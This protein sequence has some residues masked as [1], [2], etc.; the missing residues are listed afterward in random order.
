VTS[1][2][3]L[4]VRQ[5]RKRAQRL[6][7]FFR[8]SI[9]LLFSLMKRFCFA[10]APESL[11]FIA[12]VK[13]V[14]AAQRRDR[15]ARHV[16]AGCAGKDDSSPVRGGTV[17][18][19]KSPGLRPAVENSKIVIPS[20]PQPRGLR[21]ED[22]RGMCF[23]IARRQPFWLLRN[24]LR[25]NLLLAAILFLSAW[26]SAQETTILQLTRTSRPWEFLCA[27]GTRAGIFGDESGRIEAW[28][29]PL[30]ILRNF[31][32][33]FEIDG[34]LIPAETL[35]RTVTA[36]PESVSVLYTG[37]T[38]AVRE[39]FFVPV[40]EPGALILLDVDTSQPLDIRAA[41]ERDF[42]LEWPAALGGTF[43]SWDPKL[44]AFYFGE[45]Q[46]KFAA[47][48][49]SPTADDIR[50]EYQTNYSSS[51]ESSFDLGVI[52]GKERKLVVIAA[53]TQGRPDA[54]SIFQRLS[55]S[56]ESLLKESADYYSSYLA[57]TVVLDIPD[58]KLQQ[59]YDWSRIS[60]LQGV[61]NNPYLG[62]GLVAGYRTSG[63]SQRPGFAWFFGRDSFWTSFALIAAGDF[64]TS[65]AA[66]EFVSRYQRPD[67]KI[68]HEIAQSAGLV[69]WF[70]NYPYPYASADATP[71]YI[72][73]V[74]D[75]VTQSGD[76]PFAQQK[77]DSLWKAYQF[78]VST[79]D[80]QGLPQNFGIGHGWVEGGP[81]LP[82]KT[83]FYES[84]LG[85]EALRAL[86]HIAELAGKDDTSKKLSEE[87]TKQEQLLNQAFWLP[88]KNRFAFALDQD[89]K[90]I[91]EPTVLATVPMWF[92]LLEEGK[93]QPM[94]TE[95]AAPTHQADWGMRIISSSA[96][97]YNA[98]GYHYGSVWPLF[99]GWASV[100]EYRYHR[101]L[102]AFCNLKAN[103]E[104]ALD[105]SLGH[106]TE[107]LSGDYYQPLSTS[108][109]H[110]IWSAA[111]VVSPILRGLLGLAIDASAHSLTFAPH[112]PATWTSFAIKNVHAGP[113][114]LDFHYQK[115]PD[116]IILD[117][118]R[119]GS[120]DCTLEFSPAVSI[121]ADV[122]AV[123]LNGHLLQFRV[124][125]SANDQH[126]S[127]RFPVKN[128][129]NSLHI[130]LHNDFGLGLSPQLPSLGSSS[131][132]LR[133]VSESW[134]PAHDRLD[135]DIAG[136]ANLPYQLD[137]W[138][139]SEVNSADGATLEK[140][141]S[142]LGKLQIQMPPGNP[143]SYVHKKVVLHFVSHPATDHRKPPPD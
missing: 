61:V 47:L 124:L 113:F 138:N 121:T 66:L 18:N 122:P 35:T 106:V 89:N 77:W 30:K 63:S 21:G 42:Q 125:K 95:L 53:S 100:G 5:L 140:T 36:R 58:H 34:R 64:T 33:Q 38:F 28:V 90:K 92:G 41:F 54:E 130:M 45:E 82:V 29:Y 71:L 110:Q 137:V 25:P 136:L 4:Q 96:S 69:E 84:A 49:G 117:I 108:S 115:T 134:T 133:V 55:T 65:L 48:V 3:G 2:A 23:F 123:Q 70:R 101:A 32:L 91:D 111:M 83:E 10:F 19:L 128:G 93:A 119:S 8:Y 105:G 51:A 94:I 87:F 126:V 20:R 76:I 13:T 67:G 59:A 88:D 27:V 135:L 31:H 56:A 142:T 116:E 15:K 81:L 43:I 40:K 14:A 86:A 118:T 57:K 97:P 141:S 37:D 60:V 131:R 103:A 99:T 80:S 127:V 78:L 109:P 75:Y 107:V 50:E 114:T 52:K 68:P 74:N 62:T 143:D 79:Y 7:Q 22:E 102:P 6:S 85:A 120:G 112:V 132:S 73:A 26:I 17:P 139:P 72:V 1:L 9:P 39:T 12:C 46:K 11:G 24:S 44:R 16:S 98:G 129:Q 104:L